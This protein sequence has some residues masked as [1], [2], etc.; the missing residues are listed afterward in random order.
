M[1]N[2]IPQRQPISPIEA[3]VF[4]LHG[5]PPEV[6]AYSMAK[7]SRSALSMREAIADISS[8][9]ASDF[10][11]TFYFAYGHKSI[12][13]L[14]HFPM[15]VE[16][17]SLLA[18]IDVVDEQR[19]DGQ[20]RST[21]Y[22]DFSKRLYFTPPALNDRE[23]DQY[24]RAIHLLFDGYDALFFHALEIFRQ[25]NPMPR[26]MTA[27]AYER[28][29]RARTFDVA[30]YLLP[31]ATFTSV[32]QVLSARTLEGQISRMLASKYPEVNDIAA[33]LR[34]AAAAPAFN[35]DA[36]KITELL[37]DLGNDWEYGVAN[38]LHELRKLVL[39]PVAVAPTLV[40]HAEV[41]TYRLEV[42][43]LVRDELVAISCLPI[44]RSPA[45]LSSPKPL[46]GFKSQPH[47]AAFWSVDPEVEI[48]ATLLYQ[49]SHLPFAHWFAWVSDAPKFWLRGFLKKVL[50]IRGAYDELLSTFRSG[51]GI[52]FDIEMDIGGMRDLHRHR[53]VT[54]IAQQYMFT[55]FAAPE[56]PWE[57]LGLMYRA[58]MCQAQESF[59]RIKEMLLARGGDRSAA[60]YLLPLGV[61]RRFLMK[62]DVAEVAYI[63]QLRTQPAGHI[64]YRRVAWEMFKLLEEITPTVADGIRDRITDPDSPLDFFKR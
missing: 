48:A 24:H 56:M 29:L 32:G 33:K 55:S 52:I 39:P 31:M 41:H 5:A 42:E 26:D 62:M 61:N 11:N 3:E 8:Q 51:G 43:K 30:R 17:V 18:A 38:T 37:G 36:A 2:Q 40:K 25:D 16:N 14:A 60:D 12:G 19:W 54:H 46:S 58:S 7:Y 15:A 63:A 53:R 47:V 9:K 27:A 20:E 23:Q 4:A 50:E 57:Y 21:R 6:V 1:T 22:Q 59:Y 13:D 45:G 35:P 28:T 64:S 10:L 34:S 49:H 44:S